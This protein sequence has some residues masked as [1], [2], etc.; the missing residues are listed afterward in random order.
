MPVFNDNPKYNGTMVA[1]YG[2]YLPKHQAGTASTGSSGGDGG[3][4]S[5]EAGMMMNDGSTDYNEGYFQ[6]YKQDNNAYN[7]DPNQC[8]PGSECDKAK[9]QQQQQ[10]QPAKKNTN[11]NAGAGNGAGEKP[12]SGMEY[13]QKGMMG[14]GMFRDYTQWRNDLKEKKEYEDMLKRVGNTDFRLASNSPNPFGDYTMNVGP[15]N[16]F[17]LGMTTAIQDVGTVG[18]YGG[19]FKYG[20]TYEEGG[21]Y[22]V[23]E[24][25]LLQLMQN[26]AEIEFINK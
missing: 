6:A 17:Q 18:K 24:E 11:A 15:G 13:A 3:M 4:G 1:E 21:E 23:S 8:L 12:F 25:E 9:K 7:A 10:Q 5:G 19:S 14:L 26:G 16:N 20:G 2:G 22:Q